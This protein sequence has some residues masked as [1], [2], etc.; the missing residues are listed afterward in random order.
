MDAGLE[1][2]SRVLNLGDDWRIREVVQPDWRDSMKLRVGKVTVVV[3]WRP[4]RALRCPECGEV[5]KRHDAKKRTWRHLDTCQYRTFVEADVPRVKCA[6]HGVKQVPVPWADECVG[7]THLFEVEVIELL[8]VMPISALAKRLGLSWGCVA[9]IMERAVERGLARRD[10]RRPCEVLAVDET[11]FRKRHDYVTVVTDAVRGEVLYV[12]DGR[13]KSALEAFYAGMDEE[14]KQ[15]VRAVAMD[16]W[17]AYIQATLEHIPDAER[18]IAFDR[19]HVARLFNKAM[20][21]VLKWVRRELLQRGNPVLVGTKFQWMKSPDGK[22][23]R[24]KLAFHA[25][26][27]DDDCL[28]VGRA[29]LIKQTERGLWDYRSRGWAERGWKALCR[30][31]A[32]SRLEP[33]KKLSGTIRK[34]L[35][36]IINAVVLGVNNGMA[37][38]INSRIKAIKVRSCGFRNKARFQNA[39]LFHLGGLDLYPG[40]VTP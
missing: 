25:L 30:W 1:L 14:R 6:R 15:A 16:M 3:E 4:E 11:S 33:M 18:K 23:H 21:E 12:G 28:A 5:G 37:E 32:R 7:Y 19:F 39:I 31:M 22:S 34:H 40:G 8:R 20:N 10:M 38:S 13:E 35:W 9:G 24:E 29:W 2:F 27:T 26:R 36:G 17:P